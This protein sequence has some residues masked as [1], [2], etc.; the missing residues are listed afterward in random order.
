M[1]ALETDTLGHLPDGRAVE[2]YTLRNRSGLCAQIMTY[3]ATL[4]A[5]RTPDRNG[6]FENIVLGFDALAPYLA[7]TPYFG[8][9]IGRYANR[10]AGARFSVDGREYR[11]AANDGAN[12]LHGGA[13]GFDKALW[14]AR[15]LSDG[16]AFV[17]QSP[18]GDEGYPGELAVEVV[19]RLSDEDVLSIEYRA[20]TTKPTPVNLT[21]HS[22]F[23]LS[24]A[25]LRDITDH[26]LF[27]DADR[28]TPVDDNLIPTGELATVADTPFDFRSA[29]RIGAGIDAAHEQLRLAGGY[30]HN[31]ALNKPAPNA[32][33]RAAIVTDP[34]SGRVMEVWTTE[35]GLQFYSGNFLD[36]SLVGAHGAFRRRTG[37]CLEPQHFP[38]SPNEPRFPSTILR[39]GEEYRSRTEFRFSTR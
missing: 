18:D 17:L 4:T 11:L 19:Y 15:A 13:T 10:I 12:S 34:H 35:P 36:G 26:E 14:A 27:I 20:K 6:D 16:V 24:G 9:T 37:L 32:L 2:H 28:F 31:F 30:D 22:Y 29:R 25:A 21:H 5:L 7:G 33:N 3:G 8:A 38:N 23:N 39:P 1:T